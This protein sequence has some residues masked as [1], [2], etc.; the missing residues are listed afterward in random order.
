MFLKVLLFIGLYIFMGFLVCM[1]VSP[2]KRDCNLILSNI[3]ISVSF[4]LQPT[5][6]KAK[7]PIR[8]TLNI[9]FIFSPP[10]SLHQYS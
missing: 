9:F 4:E 6:E 3:D 1:E 5:I 8:I 2:R 10:I 7:Q